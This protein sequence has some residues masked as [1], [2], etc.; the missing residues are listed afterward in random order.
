MWPPG[1]LKHFLCWFGCA[2]AGRT[3]DGNSGIYISHLRPELAVT[4]AEPGRFRE[5]GT[6]GVYV[7]GRLPSDKTDRWRDK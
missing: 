6:G 3:S 4:P 1:F 5:F 2:A 7:C